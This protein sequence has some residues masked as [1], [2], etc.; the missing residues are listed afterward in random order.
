MKKNIDRTSLMSAVAKN[1]SFS[2]VPTVYAPIISMFNDPKANFKHLTEVIESEPELANRVLKIANSGYYGFSK[3][4]DTIQ[5]A[6]VLL[7]WNAIKMITLGSTILV[8]MN[9]I[10]KDLYEHSIRTAM[11]ARF[12]ATEAGFYKIEEISSVGLLHDI[13][14]VLLEIYYPENDMKVR[15]YVL[16]H[17]VPR[18]IAE[19]EIL[20]VDHGEI[21]GW[22]LEEWFIPK[23]LSASVMWHHNFKPNTFHARKTALLHLADVL[24]IA[25]DFAGPVWEKVPQ[26]DP[27]ALDTLGFSENDF[28]EI[29]YSMMSVR[30]DPFIL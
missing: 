12:I 26:L 4:V 21:G 17:G 13:G 19:R 1:P 28:K 5:R 2:K 10:N 20:G 29:F 7:G 9:E 18:H 22:M 8:K 11:I 3:K 27:A 25:V 14:I 30:L 6:V 15:Q 16:D 23:N 24:A